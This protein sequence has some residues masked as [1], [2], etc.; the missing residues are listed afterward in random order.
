M[1]TTDISNM[2]ENQDVVPEEDEVL[3]EEGSCRDTVPCHDQSQAIQFGTLFI[4]RLIRLRVSS[5]RT[6]DPT[7]G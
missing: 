2:R 1:T 7:P 3:R 6:P 4:R 5:G